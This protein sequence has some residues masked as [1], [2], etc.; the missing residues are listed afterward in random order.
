MNTHM[1]I[2]GQWGAAARER[3]GK[4]VQ[5]DYFCMCV[6]SS[7]ICVRYPKEAATSSSTSTSA[8]TKAA[9]DATTADVIDA[10]MIGQI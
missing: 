2:E 6:C 1:K 3:R 7:G 8:A 10:A 9:A 4:V 5:N